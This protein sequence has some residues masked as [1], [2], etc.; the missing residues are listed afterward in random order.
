MRNDSFRLT[1]V[2]DKLDFDSLMEG[3]SRIAAEPPEPLQPETH[4]C[5]Y[6]HETKPRTNQFF[7][8]RHYVSASG[9]P[10]QSWRPQCRLCRRKHLRSSTAN[11]HRHAGE[12]NRKGEAKYEPGPKPCVAC[13]DMPWRV[14]GPRCPCCELGYALEP[15]PELQLRRT[16]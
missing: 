8:L 6:C 11:R 4:E 15:K 2:I 7:E 1:P 10:S 9:V 12:W 16:W 5:P 14:L 3:E 13:H